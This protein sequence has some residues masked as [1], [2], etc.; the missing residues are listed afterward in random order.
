MVTLQ[1]V[2]FSYGRKRILKDLSFSVEPGQCI[3]LAG[4]NGSGKST[5]LS[6]IA[7]VL[8]PAS[9]LVQIK[10]DTGFAPQGTALFEDMTVGDN[11]QFFAGLKKCPVPERLPFGVSGYLRTRV[12]KLSGGM[13]KQVSIACALLGDPQVLVLDEPCESLDIE[14]REELIQLICLLKKEG[15]AIVYVGHDPMEF[16]SFY[17]RVVFMGDNSAVYTREEL[18][19]NPADDVCF[20]KNFSQL[21]KK[22]EGGALL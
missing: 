1:N 4:P 8:R 10:G 22:K 16:A 3:V 7:G 9:G 21:F 11:L 19:G 20:C 14:Y 5:A 6:V 12:S 2:S 17:D 13:K 15:R 18:S